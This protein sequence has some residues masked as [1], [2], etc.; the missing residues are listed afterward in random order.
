MKGNFEAP[1]EIGR[2]RT[3]ALGVG[4]LATLAI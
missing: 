3:I 1:E 2:W 4:G